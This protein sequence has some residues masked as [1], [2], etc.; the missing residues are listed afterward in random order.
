MSV[1]L[2]MRR[3]AALL[4]PLVAFVV[5]VLLLLYRSHFATG[6]FGRRPIDFYPGQYARVVMNSGKDVSAAM[7]ALHAASNPTELN[8]AIAVMQKMIDAGDAEAAFRLGRF[9]HLESA[10]PDY[11]LALKY[12]Q[13][14]VDGHHAWATNNLGLLYQ[15]GL[16]VGRDDRKAYDYFEQASRQ[17]NPWGYT[18][19]AMMTSLGR[20]LPDGAI[21]SIEWLEKGA[22]NGCTP[23]LIHEAAAYHSGAYDV[24][25][26]TDKTVALLGKASALGDSQATL[27][28]AELYLVGDG[29]PQS[30]AKAFDTL[31]ALSDQ[32]DADAT[33]RLGELSADDQILHYTFDHFLGGARQIPADFSNVFPQEP[34]RAI[35]FWELANQQGSCQSLVNLSSFYDRGVGVGTDHKRAADYVDQAVHCDPTNSFYLWKLAMRFFDA[36]GV[37]KDCVAAEKFFTQSLD[38]GDADATVD[39]GYIFDKGCGPIPEDDAR[40]FQIYLLGAKL[41]VALCQNNVGA[42]LKHGRGVKDADPARG[43]GWIK[44]AAL[45]GDELANKNLQDKLFTAEVR[46]VG[47]AHLADIQARLLVNSADPQVI[48]ND[49]WY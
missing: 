31:K 2:T 22:A 19:L 16:G 10:E 26:D 33:N 44:L 17:N 3:F 1:E 5:L 18:N 30:S 43:Y 45:K 11:A 40:A 23:C 37:A 13:I 41:G 49:P 36:N 24:R 8:A 39:L 29:V 7:N 12:Y 42:M 46:A 38:H 28:L 14:A 35:R 6:I 20:G 27:I 32:G 21:G 48:L 25:P 15:D 4:F 47:L 9:Y 34:A